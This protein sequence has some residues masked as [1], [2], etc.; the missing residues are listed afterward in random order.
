MAR[1]EKLVGSSRLALGRDG[2][3][4]KTRCVLFFCPTIV[5]VAG[6]PALYCH[7]RPLEFRQIQHEE[8]RFV[9]SFLKA[10]AT[11]IGH[12]PPDAEVA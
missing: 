10:A 6:R 7:V 9:S 11:T 2:T 4:D 3:R 1:F 12:P 8:R 5:N